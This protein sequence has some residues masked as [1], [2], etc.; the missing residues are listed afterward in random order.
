MNEQPL[1]WQTLSGVVLY[2]A[3]NPEAKWIVD[4]LRSPT[5]G[6]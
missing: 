1:F 5:P 4:C 2:A 6:W 3:F